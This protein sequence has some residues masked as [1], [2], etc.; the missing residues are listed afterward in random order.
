M[1][2]G[3]RAASQCSN[4]ESVCPGRVASE[5]HL[6]KGRGRTETRVGSNHYLLKL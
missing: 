4:T 6:Q 3:C 5:Q 1:S 2:P